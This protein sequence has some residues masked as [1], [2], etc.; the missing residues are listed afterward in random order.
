[1]LKHMANAEHMLKDLNKLTGPTH[2][3]YK[4]QVELKLRFQYM[5]DKSIK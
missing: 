4:I 3:Y 2:I 1:M 5:K